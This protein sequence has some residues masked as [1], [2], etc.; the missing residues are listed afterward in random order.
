MT[1]YNILEVS[2]DASPDEIKSAYRKLA[3]RNHPDKGGDPEKFKE[4]Q[5]AYSVLSDAEKRQMYD[6]TGSEDGSGGIGGGFGGGGGEGVPFDLS[7]MFGNIFG[8][9][10]PFGMGGMG[11][12]PGRGQRR[13]Q[14]APPKTHEIPL[15]LH[16][17]YHG[18]KINM[19]IEKQVFCEGCKGE[20]AENKQTCRECTGHG[21][22]LKFAQMGP[23]MM[24][25]TTQP[26]GACT[27]KGERI[28]SVC[29]KCDGKKFKTVKKTLEIN[30]KAGAQPGERIVFE[31]ECSD[32]DEFEKAGDI[33]IILQEAENTDGWERK[34]ADLWNEVAV[35]LGES[36]VG[37]KRILFGHPG[38]DTES[39]FEVRI[40]A[41]VKNGDIVRYDGEGMGK[42]GYMYLRIK[43]TV[44]PREIDIL[45]KNELVLRGLFAVERE[46]GGIE[47]SRF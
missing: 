27:G 40:P 23:G 25:Q 9:G 14:K 7:A 22:V 6:M 1:L 5:K 17:F 43:M 19:E 20:G 45:T 18:K 15:S 4:I 26:C 28:I 35:T 8:G 44:L 36:L 42:V 47:G 34:G 29:K 46:E 24:M 38:H 37:C 11:R 30:I 39:Q 13:G 16:D 3:L 12:A 21:M 32:T 33:H 41:G 10:M 31:G 2:K